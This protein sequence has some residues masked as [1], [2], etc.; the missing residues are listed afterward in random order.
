MPVVEHCR[1]L[2]TCTPASDFRASDMLA[3]LPRLRLV[4][5]QSLPWPSRR[6][7]ACFI[8]SPPP[9]HTQTDITSYIHNCGDWLSEQRRW[10]W[11]HIGCRCRCTP[12]TAPA[13]AR[14][15]A[16][17]AAA[18]LFYCRGVIRACALTQTTSPC[19]ES[20][21]KCVG[22][23]GQQLTHLFLRCC[24]RQ[25]SYFAWAFGVSEQGFM[26]AID[27]ASGRTF[28]FVSVGSSDT[29]NWLRPPLAPASTRSSHIFS[30]SPII[31]VPGDPFGLLTT[32][33]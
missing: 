28:I 25:E 23:N 21:S 26:G 31:P 3:L 4:P 15:C 20:A 9:P 11:Q 5:L 14:G 32:R 18:A 7:A 13:C 1:L 8:S 12:R 2:A 22:L 10:V 24:S 29:P 33:G 30:S 27:I 16:R 6:S 19:C 17:P